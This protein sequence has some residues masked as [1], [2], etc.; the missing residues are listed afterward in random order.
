MNHTS[1]GSHES[2]GTDFMAAVV[3]TAEKG[4][5]LNL[6]TAR[7]RHSLLTPREAEVS[8]L[9]ATGTPNRQIAVELGISPKTLDI[10]RANAIHKLDARTTVDLANLIN[11]IRFAEAADRPI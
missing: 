11:L 10:H 2:N 3:R 6:D 5:G 4:L 8:L 9:M 1:N 7:E